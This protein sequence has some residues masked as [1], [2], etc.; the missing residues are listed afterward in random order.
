MDEPR[1]T[2][3][4]ARLFRLIRRHFFWIVIVVV[5][6]WTASFFELGRDTVYQTNP[7][8]QDQEQAA[9]ILQKVGQLIQLPADETP[10]MAAISATRQAPKQG[11]P[12]L[13]N[14]ENGDVLIVYDNAREAL[15][16]RPSINKLIAV[17]PVDSATPQAP[18]VQAPASAPAATSTDASSTPSTKK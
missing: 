4:K 3:T 13:T 17:G 14:A 7:N 5:I 12:F 6:V 8:L 1:R 16:Y 18:A 11:Q 2:S 9:E 15:L 10:T